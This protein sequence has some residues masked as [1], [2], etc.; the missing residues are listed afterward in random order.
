MGFVLDYTVKKPNFPTV[1]IFGKNIVE[2]IF[3][4]HNDA[5]NFDIVC[6]KHQELELNFSD[7]FQMGKMNYD[8]KNLNL[9]A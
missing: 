9:L 7:G 6:L 1:F 8:K 5:N 2:D 4:K 3:L